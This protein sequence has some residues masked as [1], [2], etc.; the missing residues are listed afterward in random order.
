M[1]GAQLVLHQAGRGRHHVIRR[2]RSHQDKI[3]VIHSDSRR[4]HGLSGRIHAEVRCIFRLRRNMSCFYA[5]SCADPFIR[6]IHHFFQVSIGDDLFRYI[7][8]RTQDT[9][10]TCFHYHYEASPP[11]LY[12]HG[13]DPEHYSSHIHLQRQSH[14]RWISRWMSHGR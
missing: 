3:D 12:Y 2:R 10:I 5:C 6:C 14:C 1:G 9:G 8:T 13:Y 11:L 4:F 7:K